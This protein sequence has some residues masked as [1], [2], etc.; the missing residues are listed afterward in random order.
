MTIMLQCCGACGTANYPA[1]AVCRACLSDNL[2]EVAD[3]GEGALIATTLVHRSLEPAYAGE[4]PL[5]VG[6]V[7]LDCGPRVLV[8]VPTD[9]AVPARVRLTP[10]RNP[11]GDAVWR[12][13]PV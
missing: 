4:L 1:R 6:M 5:R 3:A 12:A 7:R 9:V 10:A 13:E 8:Y 11:T 2:T